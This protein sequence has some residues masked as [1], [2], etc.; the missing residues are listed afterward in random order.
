MNTNRTP[1]KTLITL[2][3]L[4]ALS[5]LLLV[6]PQ[7]TAYGREPFGPMVLTDT[8]EPPI[9]TATPMPPP[10]VVPTAE[11][12]A[13]G[14]PGPAVRAPDVWVVLDGCLSCVSADGFIEY[15]VHVGNDGTAEAYNVVAHNALGPGLDLDSVDMP[16]GVFVPGADPRQFAFQ[17]GTLNPGKVITFR[18]RVRLTDP[19][20]ASWAVLARA[21]TSTP[22]DPVDN[23][24]H[25]LHGTRGGAWGPGPGPRTNATPMQVMAT[26][27]P[28]KTTLLPK[29]GAELR[30]PVIRRRPVVRR[31]PVR[32]A[33]VRSPI[34]VRPRQ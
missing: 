18:I 6:A 34:I 23:N 27:T 31:R 11:P 20:A 24:D 29:T 22:G 3:G 14:I 33:P 32:R 16:E 28:S 17:I 7:P 10:P 2:A 19:N 9:P 5:A 15:Y 8:P 25:S 26:A 12:I 21:E 30:R 4:A 13:T 1:R